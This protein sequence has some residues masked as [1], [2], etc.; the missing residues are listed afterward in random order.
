MTRAVTKG[1][2]VTWNDVAAPDTEA[3]RIRREMERLF[4]AQVEPARTEEAPAVRSTAGD[5]QLPRMR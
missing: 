4:S 3:V 5:A 1:Q 2:A